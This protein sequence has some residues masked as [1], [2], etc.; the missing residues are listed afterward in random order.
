M[1]NSLSIT[2]KLLLSVS[3]LI[4]GYFITMIYGF[5]QGIDNE[6]S[7]NDVYEKMFPATQI[8]QQAKDL[9]DDQIKLYNNAVLIGDVES[10]EE[11]Q[12]KIDEIQ[13]KL[14]SMDNLSS[15]NALKMDIKSTIDTHKK[16]SL[17]AQKVYTEMSSSLDDNP[18]AMEEAAALAKLSNEILGNLDMFCEVFSDNL[19]SE[20][21]SVADNTKKQRYANLVI[22]FIVVAASL[23]FVIFIIFHFISNPLNNT[24]VMLADIV[25]GE[26]DLTKRLQ[27][28]GNDEVGKFSGSF[29]DLMTQIES[30]ISGIKVTANHVYKATQEVTTGTQGLSQ[31]TQEQ[32]ASIEEIATTVDEIT[33]TVK[34]TA[35]NASQG[36]QMTTEMVIKT[37]KSGDTSRELINAME[38]MSLVSQKIG[39]IVTTVNEVA[40]QTNLLALNA[41]IEAARAGEQGKGFA[42]VAEEVRSLAGR[43]SEASK[44]IKELIDD[45]V[46][47]IS[48]SNSLVIQ[49]NDALTD[50]IQG[51]ESL[52]SIMDEIATSSN[53]QASGIE[54][55]NMAIGQIDVTTQ[56]NAATVEELASASDSLNMDSQ[57]LED[58]VGKFKVASDV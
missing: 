57:D 43:S 23:A 25:K 44:Q 9:F 46:E 49:S 18:K 50:I 22:F 3:I 40:F 38:Q 55:V 20:L 58:R 39:N 7:L 31:S 21:V 4:T 27:V 34:K 52:S 30:L 47:K 11:A 15:D 48:S 56:Q 12:E 14:L 41:A 32:A 13:D 6:A 35:E 24:V 1:W 53:E 36:R 28:K 54:E 2:R 19:K 5:F 45:T 33:S 8:S 51:I 26:G 10:I 17:G 37:N 42:V 16:Y 29:N